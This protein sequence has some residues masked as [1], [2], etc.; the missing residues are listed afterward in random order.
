MNADALRQLVE[1]AAAIDGGQLAGARALAASVLRQATAADGT[2]DGDGAVPARAQMALAAHDAE[3]GHFRRAAQAAQRAASHF[4]QLTDIDGEACALISL[5][6][7]AAGGGRHDDAAEAALLAMRLAALLPAG[8]TAALAAH[9]LGLAYAWA[10]CHEG[11]AHALA[12]A[13]RLATAVGGGPP[14]QLARSGRAWLE[15]LRA[16]RARYFDGTLPALAPLQQALQACEADGVLEATALVVP[17][18]PGL[19][20]QGQRLA[21]CAQALLQIWQGEPGAPRQLLQA[22]RPVA[23][24]RPGQLDQVLRLWVQAEADWAGRNLHAARRSATGLIDAAVAAEWEQ[25]AG[26][27]HSLR[28]QLLRAL[29]RLDLALDEERL[30]RRREQRVQADALDSRVRAV[31][32][33]LEQRSRLQH[34]RLMAQRSQEME[35]LSLEDDLTG[36]ANRRCLEARLSSLMGDVGHEG[37]PL[38]LA[39]IDLND[40]KQVNDTHSHAT[41]DEVLRAV[42]QTIRAAVRESDLAA[43]FGGDEFVVLFPHTPIEVARQVCDRI[44]AL[45]AQLRWD[46]AAP[47]LSVGASIGVAQA[48]P[49]DT[50]AALV[51][52]ADAGMFSAKARRPRRLAA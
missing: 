44:Q 20:R 31:Q 39:L 23:V 17:G 30:L 29:G 41:G 5:S 16:A 12:E 37:P 38:C 13:E 9:A 42:A 21:R 50:A 19:G 28:G 8:P 25:M 40:F 26:L 34:L 49:G 10:R 36:I 22:A 4:Q 2:G 33:Q 48:Q 43:R 32:A 18:L 47:G 14:L 27:G 24:G 1:A 6:H 35:R 7:A 15:L 46:V 51:R 45:V 3:N 11:A 52:R